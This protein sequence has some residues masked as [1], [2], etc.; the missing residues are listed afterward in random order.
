[1]ESLVVMI[2][3]A[4]T[5]VGA[6]RDDG[7]ML[8]ALDAFCLSVGAEPKVLLGSDQLAVCKEDVCIPF[9]VGARRTLSRWMGRRFS[10][11]FTW[12]RAWPSPYR[13]TR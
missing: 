5:Q 7:R 3:G 13:G 8:V 12:R 1:M 2:N 11:S 6:Y 4:T 9:N 10:I